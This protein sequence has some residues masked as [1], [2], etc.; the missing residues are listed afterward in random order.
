MS[1]LDT[2]LLEALLFKDKTPPSK[3]KKT[4]A[5]ITLKDYIK[6][7]KEFEEFQKMLKEQ[8]DKK[9]PKDDKKDA[10]TFWQKVV[11][12]HLGAIAYLATLGLL[13]RL[14]FPH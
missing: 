4:K 12:V 10:L 11:L 7:H 8:E 2:I 5:S 1:K 6:L 9:K 13:F 3:E 14:V